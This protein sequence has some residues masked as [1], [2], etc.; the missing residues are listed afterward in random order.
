MDRRTL[1]RIS[2]GGPG[3]SEPKHLRTDG[4]ILS[5]ISFSLQMRLDLLL[6][7]GGV[8]TLQ[9]YLSLSKAFGGLERPLSRYWRFGI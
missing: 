6:A 8:W 7:F 9:S 2:I 4:S 5:G 1:S 3:M